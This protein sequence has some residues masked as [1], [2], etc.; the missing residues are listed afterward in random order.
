VFSWDPVPTATSY[1]IQQ[2]LVAPP[3]AAATDWLTVQTL[4][5]AVCTGAPVMCVYTFAT[6]P[7]TAYFRWAASNAAGKTIR[8]GEGVWHCQSCIPAALPAPPAM[9]PNLGFQ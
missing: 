5:P 8:Y 1:E 9:V 6:P 4:T 7:P 3:A 2:S